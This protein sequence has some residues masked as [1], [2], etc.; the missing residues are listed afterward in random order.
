MLGS[1][2]AVLKR[3]VVPTLVITI[4][5]A[6]GAPPSDHRNSL[7]L[8]TL[9]RAFATR[10]SDPEA[11]CVLF[12]A[13][14]PGPSLER[15]RLDAWF[16]ALQS[17]NADSS[18]WRTFLAA[19][20]IETLSARA[21]L[22][23]ATALAAEGDLAGATSELVGAP[24]SVRHHAD[25]KLLELA[26]EPTAAD[27]AVR[28]AREAPNRLRTHSR[29]IERSTLATFD[30]DDW[31][32]RAAAWRAAG[33]GSRGAT[34][35]RGLRAKDDRDRER[36]RELARC[37]LDAGS[38]TR[39]LNVLPASGKSNHEEL[40][41]R[42][43]AY[44][45]RGWGRFPD[46]A[47]VPAFR[48]CLEEA[49]RA[50]GRTVGDDRIRA[51]SL[52][53]ECGTE[54]GDLGVALAAWRQLEAAGPDHDRRDWLGRRLGVALAL[55]GAE[56]EEIDGLAS[57][58]ENHERCLRYWRSRSS[59]DPG[60]FDNLADVEVADLYGR[61]AR[62]RSGRHPPSDPAA[63]S[64]SV[65]TVMPP[66]TVDWLLTNAGP[67]EASREW[68]RLL[69]HRLPIRSEGLSAAVLAADAGLANTAIRT[70]RTTFPGIGT[71]AISEAPVDAARAYLP[72]RWPEHLEAA[73]RETGLKPW[74]IAAVARQ[75]ST[76]SA[77][78][79]S[80]AGAVGV[81]QLLPS[82]ARL[83]ARALGLGSRPN[84]EDPSV[85]IRLGARELAW[86]IRRFGAVEPALAAYNAGDRRVRRWWK[87]WPDV[88]VFTESIPIPETY[89]YVRRVVFLSDAYRNVHTDAW[90]STP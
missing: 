8:D 46:R 86:L 81:L 73:A 66:S 71:I 68:Q 51:L 67:R 2:K 38:S 64:E 34:E 80:P 72:L 60:T 40:I 56:R 59:T 10:E 24:N 63:L 45:R 49:S 20:P 90:S 84:L 48:T 25:L 83:H 70:L 69:K 1:L 39:A 19:R 53:L 77:H 22:E 89:N 12:A 52:V 16:G 42:A 6:C 15:A 5:A 4:F 75:E 23:L 32:A 57:A 62:R 87:K 41:L 79:R 33:L 76:F 35:L 43:E 85:N 28:L 7:R 13:A 88:E 9:E 31:M 74:L 21:T 14:G 65:G 54:V 50:A 82:T 47:A 29:S 27:A 55:A 37:E 44:R 3:G 58:L 18:S 61:W 17:S 26:D 36:R 30:H 78:A 11:A